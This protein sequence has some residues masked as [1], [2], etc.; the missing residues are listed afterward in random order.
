MGVRGGSAVGDA[1]FAEVGCLG[2]ERDTVHQMT[3]WGGKHD[4][5]P[6]ESEFE[7]GVESGIR[8]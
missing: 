3:I 7:I 4:G 8:G 2:A 5:L 1:A 6:V